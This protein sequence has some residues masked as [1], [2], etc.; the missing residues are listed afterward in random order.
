V[1]NYQGVAN[2]P[3]RRFF[4]APPPEIGEVVAGE[5]TLRA[6]AK[7]ISGGL[8]FGL[9]ILAGIA[10][11]AVTTLAWA[12]MPGIRGD[13]QP[14]PALPVIAVLSL[15]PFLL[16]VWSITRFRHVSG[17]IGRVG[18]VRYTVTGRVTN[19][20][21][22]EF[23]VFAEAAELRTKLTRRYLNGMYTGT[24]YTYTWVDFNGEP[25]LALSGRFDDSGR[26]PEPKNA[27]NFAEAAEIAWSNFQ[28]RRADQE[29]AQ[30]G[31]LCFQVGYNKIV[32]IGPGFI[33][34]HFGGRVDRCE[35]GDIKSI[36]LQNGQFSI[37]HR[38]ARWFS[39]KGKFSFPYG[40]MGNARVFLFAVE[41]FLPKST[42]YSG[43]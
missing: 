16:F 38:D 43:K 2:A 27:F 21:K 39:S 19:R 9:Y 17:F 1:L 34:F 8:K 22:V 23:I 24:K 35:A 33:E 25:K 41:R 37:Q 18:A 28:L 6:G 30:R 10:A 4:V 13:R 31:S 42:W 20:K 26:R 3:D 11:T 12:T 5:S 7:P 29:L 15:A 40:E 32:L 36:Q 14:G